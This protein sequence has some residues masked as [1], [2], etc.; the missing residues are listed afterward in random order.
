MKDKD[1]RLKMIRIGPEYYVPHLMH[2]EM[3]LVNA[4]WKN[5]ETWV[6]DIVKV[7]P[8]HG[9]EACKAVSLVKE[10]LFIA[11]DEWKVSDQTIHIGIREK[12]QK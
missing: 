12:M 3:G 6:D 1:R 11:V 9:K 7:A 10:N 4:A 2:M 5:F 8:P